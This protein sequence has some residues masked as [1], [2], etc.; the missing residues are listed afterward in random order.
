M[1]LHELL[2]EGHF[3][4][5]AALFTKSFTIVSEMIMI[6]DDLIVTF[7]VEKLLYFIIIAIVMLFY[8]HDHVNTLNNK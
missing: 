5:T 2:Y 3:M 8:A 6:R 7:F 1:Y 4:S